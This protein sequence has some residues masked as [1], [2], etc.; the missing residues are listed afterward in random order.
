MNADSGK[1]SYRDMLLKHYRSVTHARPVADTDLSPSFTRSLIANVVGLVVILGFV[2]LVILTWHGVTTTNKAARQEVTN[3]LTQAT[4]RLNT[5]LLAAEM[6]ASSAERVAQ[7]LS[8][9]AATL[10]PILENSLAAFEQ[11]PELSYLG[12]VLSASG[13]YVNIERTAKGDI[14]LWAF[15]PAN[16]APLVQTFKLE[17]KGFSPQ[18]SLPTHGYD[19]RTRPFYKAALSATAEGAWIPAYQWVEHA[20]NEKPLWGLSYVRALRDEAGQVIGVLDADFDLPALNRYLKSISAENKTRLYVIEMGATPRMIG[21]PDIERAPHA[22]PPEFSALTTFAGNAYVTKMSLHGEKQWVA[23]RHLQLKGGHSWI[24]VSS[25]ITPVIESSL[26]R[27]LLQVL[28]MGAAI[29]IALVLASL[30]LA[31]RFG[32]PLE[33]L[34]LQLINN[35]QTSQETTSSTSVA[36]KG[37]RETQKLKLALENMADAMHQQVLAQEQQ[38]ASAKLKSAIFDFTSTILFSLDQHL[39]VIEW[40]KAAEKLFGIKRE[41]VFGKWIG[42]IVKTPDALMDWPEVI[43][44]ARTGVYRFMGVKGLFDAEL[45]V[46]H[47]QQDGQEIYTFILN[48]VTESRHLEQKLRRDL[49]YADAVLSSLPG[50][51]YHY[52]ESL[53]LV[54]WNNNFEQTSGYSQS[55]LAG[56]D[57]M[58]FFA[59]EDQSLVKSRI[60]EVM[61]KGVSSVEVDYLLKDG[62]R[63][64]YYFT[65]VRFEHAGNLGFVGV[66]TDLTERKQAEQRIRFLA[67]NDALTG[68]ANRNQIEENIQQLISLPHQGENHFALLYIDLDRFKIVNGGYGHLFG[69]A[70]LQAAGQQLVSLVQATDVVARLGGDEFLLLIY[71]IHHPSE[72]AGVAASIIEKFNSPIQ[73]QGQDIH[74]SINIGISVYPMDG[75]T[76]NS[77][78]DNAEIAMYKAKE[79][80]NNAFQLFS[81]DMGQ[82][83]QHRVDLEI[84]LRS[85]IAEE[86]LY[87]VYQPKVNLTS[88]EITGCEA[89]IRWKHPEF[90]MV[91]PMQ[92]IPIAEDSGL[93]IAIG[94]WVLR[95]ACLQGR[96]WIDAGLPPICIAVNISVR[97]F[98]QQDLVA[99]VARTLQATG[100]PPEYLELEL[101]ESL[102]AQD[103]ERVTQTTLQLKEIGVKLS[104]DDFGTGYS[105]L[106]YLRSFHVDTLKIDQSFVRNMLTETENATIVLAVIALAH[107]LKFKVIAEGVETEQHCKYLQMHDCDEIQGYYFSKP[108]AATE[109]A[110]LLQSGQKLNIPGS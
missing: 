41:E 80:G 74:L 82:Q 59:E 9:N 75:K 19:P 28:G 20:G 25:K 61:E 89:L 65:G 76:E 23:A 73:V 8:V 53:H 50:V 62:S 109:F 81:P 45:R 42:D 63:I 69:N 36:C 11:R 60:A 1:H 101:T 13:E 93:I 100:L 10:Q 71:D 2:L 49:D 68:L 34:E 97:Q 46:M 83:T 92:F 56:A 38:L 5:L 24:V 26:Q 33:E 37:F 52:D 66:G 15:P 55:E 31:Y 84:R 48:D 39:N 95:T 78:I 51:F 102:I 86:Q 87:L 99:W 17:R 79:L 6:T 44:A 64:P 96:A 4:A 90:G 14:F 47:F 12:L 58:M 106:S 72:A 98:L 30:R 54:R 18:Q 27:Q 94:D 7:S 67:L 16:S 85:A 3:A 35:G 22:L 103:I 110:S 77:L 32:R 107:S 104:I 88:G 108:I 105:S 70:V 91:S 40:N 43:S 21:G 57:P 29:A